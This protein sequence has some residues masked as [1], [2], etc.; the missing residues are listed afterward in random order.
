M[1]VFFCVFFF[2]LFCEILVLRISRPKTG[3]TV[4]PSHSC[5]PRSCVRRAVSPRSWPEEPP[6]LGRSRLCVLS[7]CQW[8]GGWRR[9]LKECSPCF[10]SPGP[11]PLCPEACSPHCRRRRPLWM[12]DPARLWCYRWF[13]G[14]RVSFWDCTASTCASVQTWRGNTQQSH[15]PRCFTSPGWSPTN[16][17]GIGPRALENH[18]VR[19]DDELTELLQAEIPASHFDLLS[20]HGFTA[21]APISTFS[22]PLHTPA[23][24]AVSWTLDTLKHLPFSY[25]ILFF[26][27]ILT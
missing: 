6:R 22:A 10:Q 16:R 25:L 3:A 9:G 23:H 1:H 26:Y 13:P 18:S 12:L 19:M 21:L 5:V 4:R 7:A 17:A 11:A 2:F 8:V 27:F 24:E 20:T 14:R 15:L